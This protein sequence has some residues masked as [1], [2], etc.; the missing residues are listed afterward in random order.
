MARSYAY[1]F[2]LV[3][4][5]SSG[6]EYPVYGLDLGGDGARSVV[7]RCSD[8]LDRKA[9]FKRLSMALA[10][11]GVYEGQ[12]LI[13]RSSGTFSAIPS[14]DEPGE[15]RYSQDVT[16]AIL[17]LERSNS[18]YQIQACFTLSRG[19][20]LL[21]DPESAIIEFF[22]V[23]ELY[24]KQLAW[25]RRL[26]EGAARNVLVDKIILSK[27]VKDDLRVRAVL[28]PDTINLIYRMK[29]LRNRFVVHGGVRPMVAELFGDPEDYG[30]LLEESAFKY[31]PGLQYDPAFFDRALNDLSLV[32]AF[33]F[34]KMQGLEPLVCVTPERWSRSSPRVHDVLE[35]EGVRWLRPGTG[36]LRPL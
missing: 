22:K 16:D 31:D 32:G 12:G 18:P 24:I 21:A 5:P 35:A 26:S 4:V 17:H 25:V 7:L 14:E 19:Y 3:P 20:A 9:A 15:N 36:R 6:L 13:E 1:T 28:A 33:L 30:Q 11:L 34:S 8:E 29:E 23:I 2:P 10:L 27:R